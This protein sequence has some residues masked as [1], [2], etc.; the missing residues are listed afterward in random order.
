MLFSSKANFFFVHDLIEKIL[1]ENTNENFVLKSLKCRH[2]QI[3]RAHTHTH[4]S[5]MGSL[6]VQWQI[7]ESRRV[8]FFLLINYISF[9]FVN[10]RTVQ[11]ICSPQSRLTPAT[12]KQSVSFQ[13]WRLLF[14]L[15]QYALVWQSWLV[16]TQKKKMKNKEWRGFNVTLSECGVWS[17][18]V[19]E[20]WNG[21]NSFSC[22]RCRHGNSSCDSRHLKMK[23]ILGKK[24]STKLSW[25]VK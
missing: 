19:E 3:A 18:P 20:V 2:T 5:C 10:F 21:W 15:E 16:S 11:D 24:K 7:S 8:N 9:S 17:K 14:K 22:G 13:Y 1:S 4:K 25:A 23:I 12:S 6:M